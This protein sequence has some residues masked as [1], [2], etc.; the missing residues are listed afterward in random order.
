MHHS[1]FITSSKI[2]NIQNIKCSG[3]KRGKVNST[4]GNINIRFTP[5]VN[6]LTALTTAQSSWQVWNLAAVFL[7]KVKPNHGLDWCY[8]W[9][10]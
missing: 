4:L 10:Q 9:G 5:V 3:I 1:H 2:I 7:I 8:C 6:N